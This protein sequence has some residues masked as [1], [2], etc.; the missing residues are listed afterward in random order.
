MGTRNL[1]RRDGIYVANEA[2]AAGESENRG[3]MTWKPEYA[4]LSLKFNEDD[5]ALT[6]CE[7][8]CGTA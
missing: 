7:N 3:K 8:L 1:F 2:M 4:A 5:A 6:A